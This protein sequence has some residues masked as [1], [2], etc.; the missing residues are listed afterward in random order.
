MFSKLCGYGIVFA[1]MWYQ[2]ACHMFVRLALM[3]R[4]QTELFFNVSRNKKTAL[5]MLKNVPKYLS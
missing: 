5:L 4:L 2:V 3:P 1:M